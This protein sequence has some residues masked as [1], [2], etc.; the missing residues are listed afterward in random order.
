MVVRKKITSALLL[1]AHDDAGLHAGCRRMAVTYL[2]GY[3]WD[4]PADL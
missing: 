1:V 2:F 4:L 3:E